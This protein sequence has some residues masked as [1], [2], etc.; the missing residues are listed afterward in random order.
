M[1][2]KNLSKIK[3]KNK[4]IKPIT[5]RLPIPNFLAINNPPPIVKKQP[6]HIIY[7]K[8]KSIE[9]QIWCYDKSVVP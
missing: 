4:V 8:I 1:N 3:E 6:G 2:L 7:D 5:N 9:F